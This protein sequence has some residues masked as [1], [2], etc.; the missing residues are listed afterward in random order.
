MSTR[1]EVPRYLCELDAQVIQPSGSPLNATMTILSVKG[2]CLSGANRLDSGRQYYLT[3]EWSGKNL[4]AHAEVVWKNEKGQVGC[5]FLSVSDE[6]MAVIR[7][8]LTGLPLQPLR[9]V[10]APTD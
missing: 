1:R 5:R 4:R 2:C 6:S 3:T 10:T 8:I 9:A 7:E